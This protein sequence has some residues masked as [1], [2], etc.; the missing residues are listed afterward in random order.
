MRI[1]R[2][3]LSSALTNLELIVALLKF[4]I[5]ER[6]FPEESLRIRRF[7]KLAERLSGPGATRERVERIDFR[8]SLIDMG[9][10]KS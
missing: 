4:V 8:I 10:R 9:R 1:S 3:A 7:H 6:I 5:N 2:E